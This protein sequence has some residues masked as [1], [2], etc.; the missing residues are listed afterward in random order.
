M[1]FTQILI[2]TC[3]SFVASGLSAWI[4]GWL[5]VRHGLQRAQRERAFDRRLAWYEDA[6]RATFRFKRAGFKRAVDLMV[7]ALRE[8]D[9]DESL[10]IMKLVLKELHDVTQVLADTINTSLVYSSREVYIELKKTFAQVMD[11]TTD[12]TRLITKQTGD[13]SLAVAYQSHS[14]LLEKSLYLLATS[15]RSL[16]RMDEIRREDFDEDFGAPNYP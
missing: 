10:Q 2:T 4:A 14:K 9:P 7:I 5:G 12:A 13:E 16:L 8:T 6:I 1:N 15:V 11:L 3:I